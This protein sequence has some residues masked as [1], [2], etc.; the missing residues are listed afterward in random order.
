MTE[1]QIILLDK[2]SQAEREHC[3]GKY[4]TE[5]GKAI[6]EVLEELT[7][8]VLYWWNE[9]ED[10][11]NQLHSLACGPWCANIV[12]APAG[13]YLD[14]WCDDGCEENMPCS[15]SSNRIKRLL[16]IIEPDWA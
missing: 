13:V 1:N 4:H 8:Q 5:Q 2:I 14:G 9:H 11:P 15:D 6:A 7:K 3:Y 16:D 10:D 12:S